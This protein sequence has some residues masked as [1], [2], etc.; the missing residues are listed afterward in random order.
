M[1]AF[2]AKDEDEI[3][4]PLLKSMAEENVRYFEGCKELKA[5][6]QQR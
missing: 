3:L 1:N 4:V 6:R 5:L 2:N